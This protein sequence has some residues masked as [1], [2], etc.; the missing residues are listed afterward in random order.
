VE[1]LLLEV[2]AMVRKLWKNAEFYT[3]RLILRPSLRLSRHSDL[4]NILFKLH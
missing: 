2:D 1:R 3:R 4:V